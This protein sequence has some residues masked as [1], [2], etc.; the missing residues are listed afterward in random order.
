MYVLQGIYA[1]PQRPFIRIAA[2][3][4]PLAQ[5]PQRHLDTLLTAVQHQQQR[6]QQAAMVSE[7][8]YIIIYIQ[9]SSETI[10]RIVQ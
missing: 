1:P 2:R 8:C 9:V 3:P 5:P 7:Q 4:Q 10:H 6:N